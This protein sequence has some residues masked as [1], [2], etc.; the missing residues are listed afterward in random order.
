MGRVPVTYAKHVQTKVTYAKMVDMATQACL[1]SAGK[2]ET[3]RPLGLSG[4][5]LYPNQ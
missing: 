3:G 4:Q 5:R 1:S 2:V